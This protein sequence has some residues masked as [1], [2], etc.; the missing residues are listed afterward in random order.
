MKI[1]SK[2]IVQAI[3]QALS[4]LILFL[5][6]VYTQEAWVDVS[7]HGGI[8]ELKRETAVSLFRKLAR[9]NEGQFLGILVVCLM[10]I[11]MIM[12]IVQLAKRS[13]IQIVPVIALVTV[14]MFF[15]YSLSCTQ[16]SWGSGWGPSAFYAYSAAFG[17]ILVLALQITMTLI[18]FI[19]NNRIKQYGV[20]ENE[21]PR[22]A[23][24]SVSNADE[25][26]KYKDLLD[27]GVI[28]QEEFDAK[29]KQLL[30][31]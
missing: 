18:G 5:P 20:I 10:A 31:L 9:L 11:V 26:G 12:L 28:T 14:V 27:K 2:N 29:K 30:G 3:I 16:D 23:Q 1:E 4:I 7:G 21:K 19:S 22:Y 8:Y 13:H 17:F 24:N 6:C 25:L 15:I